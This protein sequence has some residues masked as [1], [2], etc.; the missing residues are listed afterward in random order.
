MGYW[1]MTLWTGNQLAQTG[2]RQDQVTFMLSGHLLSNRGLKIEQAK[3]IIP[4]Y[5]K[6]GKNE[7]S[8][9]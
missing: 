3:H 4:S 9:K 8:K 2:E 5:E 6:G 7:R 1:R